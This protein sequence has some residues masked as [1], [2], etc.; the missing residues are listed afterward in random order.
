MINCKDLNEVR[1]NIDRIDNEI[2]KLISERSSYVKQAANF[3]KDAEDVKAPQ[4][5]EMVIAKVRKLAE[6]SNVSPDIV[7]GIYREMISSFINI[8]LQEHGNLESKVVR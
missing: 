6:E 7:E 3:K 5:V 1:E 8:E 2:V 4:R